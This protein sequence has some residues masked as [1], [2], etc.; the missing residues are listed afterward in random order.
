MHSGRRA[1]EQREAV[2]NEIRLALHRKSN[3]LDGV[4]QKAKPRGPGAASS[5]PA[6]ARPFLI[7]QSFWLRHV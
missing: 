7:L 3:G 5:L 6:A 1:R 2:L 4:L